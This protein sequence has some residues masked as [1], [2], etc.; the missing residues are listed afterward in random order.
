MAVREPGVNTLATTCGRLA[1]EV[2]ILHVVGAPAQASPTLLAVMLIVAFTSPSPSGKIRVP[3]PCGPCE[4]RRFIAATTA[5]PE[6]TNG[7]HVTPVQ[8]V[9]SRMV[10]SASIEHVDES[11]VLANKAKAR[12]KI[13]REMNCHCR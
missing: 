5:G 3:P 8:S 10:P 6:S 11:A 4:L 9:A 1:I 2:S 7:L 12:T 13:G